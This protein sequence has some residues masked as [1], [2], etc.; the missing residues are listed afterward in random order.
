M[1]KYKTGI[2]AGKFFPLHKGHLNCIDK[3]SSLCET[4]YLVF[5]NNSISEL[6]RMEEKEINYPIEKRVEYAKKLFDGT[7]VK[8]I[9]YKVN[10]NL[11]FPTDF[12]EVKKDLLNLIGLEEIDLQIFGEDEEKIY[13]NFLYAKE[14]ITCEHF[15]IQINGEEIKLSATRIRKDIAK[16]KEYMP[17]IIYNSIQEEK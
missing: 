4:I 16:L 7:N 3:I 13:K 10:T 15:K 6:K 12:S 17:D 5:Y 8:V 9:N 11:Y 14:Y 2:F 1:K